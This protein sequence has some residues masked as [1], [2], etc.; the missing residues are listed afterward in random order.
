MP[1]GSN[2]L[3]VCQVG[4][5]LPGQATTAGAPYATQPTAAFSL[6]PGARL[7]CELPR[8]TGDVP[9]RRT[10]NPSPSSGTGALDEE[11]E[12]ALLERLTA[13]DA[14]P[15]RAPPVL[16]LR[17]AARCGARGPGPGGSESLSPSLGPSTAAC[18][19]G[20]GIW[21]GTDGGWSD[22]VA[23][24]PGSTSVGGGRWC[25]R[26]WR[27]G[28]TVHVAVSP[29]AASQENARP[30]AGSTGAVTYSHADASGVSS[31]SSAAA[32]APLNVQLAVES[33]QVATPSSHP[34][35]L[36]MFCCNAPLLA[37]LIY[38]VIMHGKH[39]MER[40]KGEACSNMPSIFHFFITCRA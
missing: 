18:S 36:C 23:L 30:G 27:R 34:A 22:P 8:D 3:H 35:T 4:A 19:D 7:E 37:F 9:G 14:Q 28:F 20:G 16:R 26:V 29:G 38:K 10:L 6:A 11:D 21:A 2:S 5:F 12:E 17:E 13:R 40:S 25:V 31:G 1:D 24:L 33:L 15:P 32:V 39:L